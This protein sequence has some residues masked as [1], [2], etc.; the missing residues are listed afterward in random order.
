MSCGEE[1]FSVQ[2]VPRYLHPPAVLRPLKPPSLVGINH[3]V[4]VQRC[5]STLLF[6]PFHDSVGLEIMRSLEQVYYTSVTDEFPGVFRAETRARTAASGYPDADIG[7]QDRCNCKANVARNPSVLTSYLAL[8][9]NHALHV[10]LAEYI[11]YCCAS[12]TRANNYQADLLIRELYLL[13][14]MQCKME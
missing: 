6:F 12:D 2:S 5:C 3:L 8:C 14:A 1:S 10:Y 9:I 13:T 4:D 11:Q 7:A